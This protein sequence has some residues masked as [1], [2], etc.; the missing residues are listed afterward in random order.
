MELKNGMTVIAPCNGSRTI[1]K[2]DKF[3]VSN[4]KTNHFS[5]VVFEINNQEN[6]CLLKG[7]A[8]INGKD[9]IIKQE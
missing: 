1:K 7:C 3:V 9:W 8:H 4:V 2:G 5:M 6:F